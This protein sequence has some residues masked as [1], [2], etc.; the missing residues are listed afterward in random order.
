MPELPEVEVVVRSLRGFLAGRVIRELEVRKEK[1]WE[2]EAGE[3]VGRK[4]VDIGRRARFVLLKLDNGK[5]ILTHLKMTG[6]L[7]FKGEKIAGGG[8]PTEDWLEQLPGKHTRIVFTLDDGSHLFFNDQRIFGYMRVVDEEELR[9]VMGKIG[10]DANTSE[11]GEA[12]LAGKIVKRKTAIKQ[13]IMDNKIVAGVGNIYAQESLFRARID[14]RRAGESLSGAEVGRI[15][16]EIKGILAEAIAAGGTTFDGKY[17]DGEGKSGEFSAKLQVYGRSGEKCLVCG[18][19]LET[20]R[21]GGR[22]TV[23]C[24]GCQGGFL[25]P[26]TLLIL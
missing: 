12:Y 5:T 14:P 19:D 15:V 20:I 16:R 11:F 25:S 6:Q 26:K 22:R 23:Y 21:Q 24:L 18:A 10:P 9:E 4:I 7:I 1:S 17:V 2:G 13:L 3:V 8:H